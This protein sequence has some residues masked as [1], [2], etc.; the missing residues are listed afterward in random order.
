LALKRA[1][2]LYRL[3]LAQGGDDAQS[4]IA[5]CRALGR[6]LEWDGRGADAAQAY[7]RAAELT[8]GVERSVLASTAALQLIYAGAFAEGARLLRTSLHELDLPTP[9]TRLGA[10]ASLVA[11]RLR[12]QG[13][14]QKLAQPSKPNVSDAGRARVDALHSAAFGFVFT[15]PLLGECMQAAHLAAALREGTAQQL[16]RALALEA[17][18]RAHR[19]LDGAGGS[20]DR[21]FDHAERMARSSADAGFLEFV[22]AC[23]GV[24]QFLCGNWQTAHDILEQA[25]QNVPRHQAGWHTSAWIY[26]VLALINRGRFGQVAERLPR[27]LEAAEERGDRFTVTMLRV[28]ANVPLQLACGDSAAARYELREGMTIWDQPSFLVQHWRAMWWSAETDLYDGLA[29]AAR[30]R[31][32]QDETKLRKSFL[33]RVQYIRAMTLFLR[34]RCA[35]A[36]FEQE[37]KARAKELSGLQRQLAAEGRAWTA[38]LAALVAAGLALRSRDTEAALRA[39]RHGAALA[40]RAGLSAHAEACHLLLGEQLGGEEG[41]ALRRNAE[42]ELER[43]GVRQPRIFAAT[44]LPSPHRD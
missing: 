21:L 7:L 37:P 44:L 35:L 12:L 36:T 28:S 19:S 30:A 39:L 3:A 33:L 24:S 29:G 43:N 2:A 8:S 5:V 18:Q 42:R 14:E 25:Y 15:D 10:L 4:T 17:S 1:E 6:V 38:A 11:G 40:T 16:A 27:L 31:C 32:V 41:R 20:A 26:N 9:S 23:R 22:H 13:L 34:A